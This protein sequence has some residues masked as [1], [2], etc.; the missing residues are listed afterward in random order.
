MMRI[1]ETISE[2]IFVV[3]TILISGINAKIMLRSLFSWW[4]I[5]YLK[6]KVSILVKGVFK[7]KKELKWIEERYYNIDS[8]CLVS[9][10]D[11]SEPFFDGQGDS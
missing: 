10:H 2:D 5:K 7:R 9:L 1:C 3:L 6:N 8:C 4:T 11:L